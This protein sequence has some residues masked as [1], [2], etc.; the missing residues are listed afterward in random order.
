MWLS[1]PEV[2]CH[3]VTVIVSCGA[4]VELSLSLV[5][6]IHLLNASINADWC[7]R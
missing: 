3:H 2:L 1:G 6:A 5:I 7:S 4:R